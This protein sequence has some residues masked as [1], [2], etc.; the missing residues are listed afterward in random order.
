MGDTPIPEEAGRQAE[1]PCSCV[2]DPFG[3]VPPEEWPEP[4]KQ[5]SLRRVEC[6]A[7]GKEYWTN[8]ET[9]LC[10]DCE[11]SRTRRSMSAE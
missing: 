11:R 3:A 5:G 4:R 8:R 7:C 2:T 6:P 1:G 9:Y 10:M